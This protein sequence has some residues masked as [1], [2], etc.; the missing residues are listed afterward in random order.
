MHLPWLIR[1][2]SFCVL[3]FLLACGEQRP[4]SVSAQVTNSPDPH[5]GACPIFSANNVWNRP[6]Q[7]RPVH[8]RSADYVNRIGASKPVHPNFGSTPDN[9]IPITLITSQ[10]AKVKVSFTYADES[11]PGGYPIPANAL[12]EG[13]A[14]APSGTDRHI[15]LVDQVRCMLYELGG[16]LPQ[17]GGTW[18]AGAGIKMDLMSDTLR[19]DT[20][21]S[22]DA[23]GLP[24][25]PG[26]L[27]YDEVAQGE[28]RHAIRFTAPQTQKAHVW[29]ARHDAS[30]ITDESY[31]PMGT[32]FRL[33]A[34]FDM[35]GFS[36]ENQVILR[37]LQRYGM[38][39]ADNGSSWF[40]IGSP[41]SRWN[42]DDLHKL[43]QVTGS[44]FEAVD[45]SDW[46]MA[47]SS[48]RTDPTAG[49]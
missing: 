38:I 23:A 48:A 45:V 9:G 44:N 5:I 26:L 16:A 46:E 12:I 1:A 13:G 41:D 17:S 31:P 37:A 20:W 22:T 27:R 10:T 35:S 36:R 7:T 28:I 32:R 49:S 24:V 18:T 19:P 40:L 42:D 2:A 29:P 21:T 25:L 39:L 33:K 3:A 34:N 8:T 6:I 30:S 47:P 43:Q 15:I 14:N 4:A 11:D